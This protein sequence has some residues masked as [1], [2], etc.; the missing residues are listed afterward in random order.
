VEFAAAQEEADRRRLGVALGRA[1]AQINETLS[2]QRYDRGAYDVAEEQAGSPVARL[3]AQREADKKKAL[4]D[5][6]SEASRRVQA[7]VAK[8]MPGVYTPEELSRITAADAPMVTQY[9]AMRQRLEERKTDMAREDAVRAVAA[10]ER[11]AARKFEAQQ[12]G[13][14]RAFQAGESA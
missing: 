14:S 4:G 7:A 3:L 5:P 10:G 11:E 1:G 6:T 2:G 12:A 13:A 8:A 9:G